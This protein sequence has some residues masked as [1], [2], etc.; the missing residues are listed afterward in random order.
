MNIDLVIEFLIQHSQWIFSGVGTSI[1]TYILVNKSVKTRKKSLK[2]TEQIKVPVNITEPTPKANNNDYK[3]VLGKRHKWLRE[4]ILKLSLR[5]MAEFYNFKTVSE[6]ETCE[7][8]LNELPL[9]KL[10]MI[11]DFFFVTPKFIENGEEPIFS[12]YYLSRDNISKYI[13]NEFIPVIACSPLKRDNLYCNIVFYKVE[14]GL[15]R[16]I[17]ADREG[18][19]ASSGGGKSNI[20]YLIDEMLDRNISLNEVGILTTTEKEWQQLMDGR[21][22]DT[23]V[24]SRFSAADQDC[25]NVF[26]NWY[27]AESNNRKA[28]IN[29]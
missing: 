9:E 5:E 23:K 7:K 4:T 12:T 24:F 20:I 19:F 27:E 15:Y 25:M 17:T 18:S 1:I 14:N 29:V 11:E 28:F 3:S 26:D 8:G 10:R 21:Y 16:I 6:L 2:I 22:Y 13:D